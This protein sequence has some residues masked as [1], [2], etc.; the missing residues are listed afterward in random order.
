M[1]RQEEIKYLLHAYGIK[2]SWLA[3][4]LGLKNQ[5]LTYLLNEAPVIDD[6]LFEQVKKILDDYQFN[7]DLFDEDEK[8]ADTLDLFTEDNLLGHIGERIRIFAKRKYGTLKKLAD[9][10]QIS[11]QQLQQYVS[12][13]RDPGTKILVRL[14]RAGCD[15][16]WL[17]GGSESMESYRNYLLENELRKLKTGIEQIS[18]I[19][20]R[21]EGK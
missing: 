18:Q 15:I 21:V 1:T 3:E 9:A 4:K 8:P 7:L 2:Q 13:N 17:L 16:N 6:D 5:T 11:P 19:I 12:G 10:M 14:L 20:K